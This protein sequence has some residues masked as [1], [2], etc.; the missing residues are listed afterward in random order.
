MY[1][2][3][4]TLSGVP[5]ISGGNELID[6]IQNGK[7]IKFSSKSDNGTNNLSFS[8]DTYKVEY[9]VA[10]ECILK[11][12]DT[13]SISQREHSKILSNHFEMQGNIECKDTEYCPLEFD[14]TDSISQREHSKILSNHFEMQGN[15][16]CKDTEYCPLEFDDTDSVSKRENSKILPNNCDVQANSVNEVEHV[17]IDNALP[18]E[19]TEIA[20][21]GISCDSLQ[22]DMTILT[23]EETETSEDAGIV[24]PEANEGHAAEYVFQAK[25]NDEAEPKTADQD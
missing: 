2:Q 17:S 8:N 3:V 13:G 1:T 22:D 24:L 14:D 18:I 20:I 7:E 12:D 5:L 9:K 25:V 11:S 16:E 15:I 23:K 10:E 6:E 21:E 19:E 4:S